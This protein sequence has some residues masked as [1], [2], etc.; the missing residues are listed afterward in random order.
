MKKLAIFVEGPTEEVFI[1]KLLLEFAKRNSIVFK[2]Q[3]FMG[4]KTCSRIPTIIKSED[5]TN[6]TKYYIM[7]YTSCNDEKVLSDYKDKYNQLI[8]NGYTA[9]LGLRDLYPQEYEDLE[10]V[11]CSINKILK[12]LGIP[13]NIHIA[14]REIETWFL[15]EY[16]HFEK[17]HSSINQT[18]INSQTGYLFPLEEYE[19]T[20]LE[21][22]KT[23]HE[24]YKI[25][26]FA[27][28]KK[29]NQ[30]Q[31]TVSSID[32]ENFYINVREQ[33]PSLDNF[34]KELDLFFND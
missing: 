29:A 25:A 18:N 33:I 32:Y 26:G 14:I 5:A 22:A 28:Q 3:R 21:P 19:K 20:I 23:L 8:I 24:I 2:I 31:R 16:S 1:E 9:I 7:I 15:A 17:I 10:R 11:K 6:E 13:N 34:L 30:V 4:G 27:Y 12:L